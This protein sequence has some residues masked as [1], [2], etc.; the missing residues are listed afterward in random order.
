MSLSSRVLMHRLDVKAP[1][2]ETALAASRYA[3]PEMAIGWSGF[4]PN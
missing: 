2:T 4:A 1:G 3:G